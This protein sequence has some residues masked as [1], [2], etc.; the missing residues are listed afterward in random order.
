MIIFLENGDR[1][2]TQQL[3]L[4]WPM[5]QSWLQL[6]QSV[7]P[8]GASGSFPS[9]CPASTHPTNYDL[10]G[11][12]TQQALRPAG[13]PTGGPRRSPGGFPGTSTRASTSTRRKG[14]ELQ[15][16]IIFRFEVE[17]QIRRTKDQGEIKARHVWN[18]EGRVWVVFLW[19]VW[20]P[21][22]T[23][24]KKITWKEMDGKKTG[25]K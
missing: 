17:I 14:A 18:V 20:C 1:W 25:W 10:Q 16:Q 19:G 2:K 5:P 15:V 4:R 24:P 23:T 8:T 3:R 9:T 7:C 11:S 13:H 6:V 12:P 21:P 22:L